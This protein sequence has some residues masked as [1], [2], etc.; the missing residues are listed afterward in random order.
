ML[1]VVLPQKTIPQTVFT[2]YVKSGGTLKVT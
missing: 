2:A 1:S